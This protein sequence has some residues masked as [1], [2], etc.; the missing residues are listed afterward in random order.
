MD[1]I[2][3]AIIAGVAFGIVGA[4]ASFLGWWTLVP[5]GAVGI[6]LGYRAGAVRTGVVGALYGFALCLSFMIAG[7]TGMASLM[8]RLPFFALIGIVGA[9]CGVPLALVGAR[10]RKPTQQPTAP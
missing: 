5:W 6:V 7:Y 10:L 2:L 8:S 4:R 9:I 3:R 1:I